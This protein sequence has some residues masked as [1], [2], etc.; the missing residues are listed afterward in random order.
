MSDILVIGVIFVVVFVLSYV[1]LYNYTPGF[2]TTKTTDDQGQE[3]KSPNKTIIASI[4]FGIAVGSSVL[5]MYASHYM[6]QQ[7][8]YTQRIVYSDEQVG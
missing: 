7:P 3:V 4:S 2:L 6:S 1:L 5:Y 8:G